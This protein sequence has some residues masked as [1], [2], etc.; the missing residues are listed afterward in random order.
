MEEGSL[1]A[2]A[3]VSIR[4]AGSD[5][6]GT[7]TEIK[8]V[9][10]FSGIHKAIAYEIARQRQVIEGGGTL[11]QETRGW[12]PDKGVTF[13]Q[14]SK[15]SAHDYRYFPEPDLVPIVIDEAWEDRLRAALPE[16]PRARRARFESEYGLSAYDAG[17]LTAERAI[18]DYFEAAV[19]AGAASKPAANWVMGDLQALLTEAK[20]D[21]GV[22]RV[23]P[24]NLAAMIRLIEDGTISG[25]I[26]KELLPEMLSTGEAPKEL[27]ERKGLVQISDERALESVAREVVRANPGPA[28]DYRGGKE[29]AFG[30]LVGQLMKATKGK[31]NPQLANEVLRKVLSE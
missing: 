29:R 16:L 1:R 3:N 12:D 2:E 17:V 10:S 13:S 6:F 11:V 19:R 31:A 27:V 22:C 21:F 7:K 24:D 20:Q 25:K 5:R 26:A 8:N 14:R 28:A 30:F 9:A 15:E 4:P 18:A 23:T